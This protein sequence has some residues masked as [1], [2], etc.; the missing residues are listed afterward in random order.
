MN[1]GGINA[2]LLPSSVRFVQ[3]AC[4]IVYIVNNIVVQHRVSKSYYKYAHSF[5]HK[6]H[7]TMFTVFSI[8]YTIYEGPKS[9]A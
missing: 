7:S 3:F 9:N 1:Q 6:Q 8:T 5:Y 4:M 2:K